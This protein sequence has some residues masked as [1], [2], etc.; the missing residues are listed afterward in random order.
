[1]GWLVKVLQKLGLVIVG[2]FAEKAADEI[3]KASKK[4]KA[5]KKRQQN[6]GTRAG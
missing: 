3:K 1:M 4:K 5:P 6:L 2:I